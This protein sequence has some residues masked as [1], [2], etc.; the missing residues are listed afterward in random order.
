MGICTNSNRGAGRLRS[1]CGQYVARF[2][3]AFATVNS[4]LFHSRNEVNSRLLIQQFC[5]RVTN[6]RWVAGY[7]VVHVHNHT[8]TSTFVLH[9][10]KLD[11]HLRVQEEIENPSTP[12]LPDSER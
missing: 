3:F 9:G 6:L 8:E 12:P 2:H 7:F 4:E 11:C 10:A 5:L 1:T